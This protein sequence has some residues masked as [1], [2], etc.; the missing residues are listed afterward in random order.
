V[1][2]SRYTASASWWLVSYEFKKLRTIH[3]ERRHLLGE[4]K[5]NTKTLAETVG[6]PATIRTT[7]QKVHCFSQVATWSLLLGNGAVPPG[8]KYRRIGTNICFIVQEE[9][10]PGRHLFPLHCS[11]YLPEGKAIPVHTMKAHK[12]AKVLTQSFLT[13]ALDICEWSISRPGRPTP[14]HIE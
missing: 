7:S 8:V 10:G 9:A 14:A 4:S 5:E 13:S 3:H 12:W 6:V 1:P 11:L 2:E